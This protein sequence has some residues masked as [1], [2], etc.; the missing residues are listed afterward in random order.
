MEYLQ[1]FTNKGK[2]PAREKWQPPEE[3]VLKVNIDGSFT[4]GDSYG[5]WGV[6]VRDVAGDVIAAY[7][8]RGENIS[9]AFGAE[10]SAMTTAIDVAIGLGAMRVI[11]E[12]DY[13]LLTKGLDLRKVDSS[14]YAAVIKDIKLQLKLWFSSLRMHHCRREVRPSNAIAACRSEG[15][16]S[17]SLQPALHFLASAGGSFS[18]LPSLR[19][20]AAPLRRPSLDP[21][22]P[23]RPPPPSAACAPPQPPSAVAGPP[24]AACPV[25]IAWPSLRRHAPPRPP[26]AAAAP[27]VPPP[28]RPGRPAAAPPSAARPRRPSAAPPPR[29]PQPAHAGPPERLRPALRSPSTPA[30]RSV[31]LRVGFEGSSLCPCFSTLKSGENGQF[32]I[33]KTDFTF[34]GLR[35]L[36]E[37]LYRVG[38]IR[39]VMTGSNLD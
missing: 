27:A 26:S 11:F 5:G 22:P 16:G 20:A 21:P 10:V 37:M 9:D 13:Q 23:P 30:L 34:K 38:D 35:V 12:T 24:S 8:G 31:C 36:L 4:L 2:K 28:P 7:A 1:Y 17:F 18:F 25:R 32:S 19:S 33:L 15:W 3:D 6:M 29:P 39:L 14:P